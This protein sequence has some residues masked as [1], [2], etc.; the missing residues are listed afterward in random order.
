MRRYGSGEEFEELFFGRHSSGNRLRIKDSEELLFEEVA[1]QIIDEIR[2]SDIKH[3]D[4]RM[5]AAFHSRI[6][7]ELEELGI[8]ANGF[9][10]ATTIDTDLDLGFE[11]DGLLFLPA[12][13]RSPVTIDLFNI[14][15][16]ALPRNLWIDSRVGNFSWEDY[17]SAL[18]QF[19]TGMAKWKEDNKKALEEGF[20]VIKPLDLRV[21]TDRG[22]PRSH[23]IV[24]PYDAGTYV[25]RR[26]FANNVA[27]YFASKVASQGLKTAQKSHK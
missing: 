16:A 17:Q 15:R 22:R 24:T 12:V 11:A 20:V 2:K 4:T 14:D 19:K 21:Y 3:P 7:K 26:R 23:F 18:Y 10:L 5:G 25:G 9:G 13:P 1:S 8:D 27:R 6:V